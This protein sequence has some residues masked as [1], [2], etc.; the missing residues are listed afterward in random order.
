MNP[1]ARM[2]ADLLLSRLERV[3]RSGTGWRADCPNGHR[4]ARGTLSIAEAEDGRILL[5]CFACG[6]VGAILAALELAA[7]DLF[8]ERVKDPSPEGRRATR[9]EFKRNAWAAALRVLDREACIV[10]GAARAHLDGLNLPPSDIERLA[11]AIER[12]GRA[13]EVLA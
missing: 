2:G 1:G 4:D 3:K 12:I 13:R 10:A 5:H 9:E 6:D 11:L 8:P 7:A